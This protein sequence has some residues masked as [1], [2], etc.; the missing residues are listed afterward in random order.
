MK[1]PSL[2]I[3]HKGDFWRVFL[4]HAGIQKLGIQN[5]DFLLSKSKCAIYRKMLKVHFGFAR[6][7][8]AV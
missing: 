8:S 5:V 7:H 2:L 1:V 3:I 6:N 4:T